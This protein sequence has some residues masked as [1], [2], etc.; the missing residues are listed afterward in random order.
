MEQA[1]RDDSVWSEVRAFADRHIRAITIGLCLLVVPAA[2]LFLIPGILVATATPLTAPI[3]LKATLSVTYLDKDGKVIGRQGPVAGRY[4]R[5]ARLPAYLPQAFLAMEDRRFYVHH[6]VDF[7]GLSRAAYSDLRA[8]RLVA[9]GSTISQQTAKLLF[10]D[11]SR[12]FRRKLHELVNAARLEKS[13]S[14]DQILEIYLNRIYLGEGTFGVDSA[15]RNYFGVPAE[16]LTLPQA[17]MLAGLTRAPTLYS[18]RRNL[19]TAQKRAAIALARMADTGAITQAQAQTA[20]ARPAGIIPAHPD[21]HDYVLDAAAGEVQRLVDKDDISA[22]A[23]IVHTTIDSS[24]QAQAKDI[25]QRNVAKIGPKLGF[26]Q[27]ALVLMTPR[28]DILSL[29]GGTDYSKSVFDRVTQA[30]RQPGSAFKPFVYLAALEHGISP[31]ELRQDQPVDIAGYQPANYQN[32]SYGQLRLVDALARSVNTISVNLA[33]E[34]GVT[35]V[36][37]VA[38][39]LGITSPLHDNASLALGTDEVTPLEL[40][41]AY[42]AFANGGRRPTPHLVT[43]LTDASGAVLYRRLEKEQAFVVSDSVR[44]DMTA[45]LFQVVVAGTGTAA[46]L[47]GREAGGKTGTTQEYR[48]AWFVGFTPAHVAGVWIGNDDNRPMRKVTGGS[49]PAQIWKSVMLAAEDHTPIL[50]LDRSP[51]PPEIKSEQVAGPAYLDDPASSFV[52][53]P[54]VVAETPTIAAPI[55]VSGLA[56]VPLPSGPPP[57]QQRPQF[58]EPQPT[59]A[60][61]G[62]EAAN[63]QTTTAPQRPVMLQPAPDAQALYRQQQAEYRQQLEEYRRV[64]RQA[65]S[66][67]PDEDLPYRRDDPYRTFP[68]PREGVPFPR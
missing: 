58:E 12:T 45:M 41:A 1:E 64:L 43:S 38:R 31:W 56:T 52:A 15:A 24:L 35:N 60:E 49:V 22:R 10:T 55:S 50:P 25:V 32:A 42:G 4:V 21:D 28:G 9:G 39:R 16:Q 11:G 7:L 65:T 57:E 8:H 19:P 33:Q 54:Q 40:T 62:P 48:D 14:K 26:S 37:A 5:L 61:R 13:F 36:A 34:V 59:L 44:R 6:G 67:A 18:P 29:V 51:A 46:R 20:A 53:A 2:L 17:A 68:P 66:P 30:H 47:P 3:R 23:L 27:A 63:P